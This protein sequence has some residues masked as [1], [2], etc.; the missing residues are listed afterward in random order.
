MGVALAK[1][2]KAL[3]SPHQASWAVPFVYVAPARIGVDG[4]YCLCC[5]SSGLYRC[6][7]LYLVFHLLICVLFVRA[8]GPDPCNLGDPARCAFHRRHASTA[9]PGRGGAGVLFV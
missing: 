3:R 2:G 6:I 1:A 7:V 8:S 5:S 4:G 9:W